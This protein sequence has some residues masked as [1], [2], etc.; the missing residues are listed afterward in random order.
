M[1]GTAVRALDNVID[2][3][4]YPLPYAKITNRRYRS[5]G[6]LGK[7]LSPYAGKRGFRWE[8][9]EHLAFVDK[10]FETINHAAVSEAAAWQRKREPTA[11]FGEATGQWGLFY[12]ERIRKSEV[13]G[14]GLESTPVRNAERIS[15]CSSSYQ[16]YQ[17]CVRNDGGN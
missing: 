12:Q 1:V 5:I 11:C 6:L 16:Q 14:V 9:E 17:Y 8:S 3:N 13:A 10:V 7:R 15:P 2:L 4:F